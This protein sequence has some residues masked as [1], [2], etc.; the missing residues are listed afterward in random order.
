MELC[1]IVEII[2]PNECIRTFALTEKITNSG[3]VGGSIG[4]KPENEVQQKFLDATEDFTAIDE[5]Y[6]KKTAVS[7]TAAPAY[8]DEEGWDVIRAYV[9]PL[10]VNAFFNGKEPAYSRRDERRDNDMDD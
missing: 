5:I 3:F 4:N 8:V 2:H 10:I 7:I 6:L 1:K 9:V